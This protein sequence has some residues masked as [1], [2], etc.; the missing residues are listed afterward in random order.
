MHIRVPSPLPVLRVARS[1]KEESN[2]GTTTS[3]SS[4]RIQG[5]VFVQKYY[6]NQTIIFARGKRRPTHTRR[7]E[8]FFFTLSLGSLILFVA[9]QVLR[10]FGKRD[11]NTSTLYSEQ[12]TRR[13]RRRSTSSNS[14]LYVK[15]CDISVY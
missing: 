14:R 7:E 4:R 13:S 1:S 15:P 2:R 5:D 8:S 3:T 12:H 11:S 6:Q 10:K 9:D